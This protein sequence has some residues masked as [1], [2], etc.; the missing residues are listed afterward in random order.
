MAAPD[1]LDTHERFVR[2]ERGSD[3]GAPTLL[4]RGREVVLAQG[5]VRFLGN[6]GREHEGVRVTRI[7]TVSAGDHGHTS[8]G[9]VRVEW[10][11]VDHFGARAIIDPATVTISA[12]CIWENS[13]LARA[14]H[15]HFD[16]R[17]H[18]ASNP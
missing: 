3:W 6:D 10:I 17:A 5:P 16:S 2:L 13:P 12:D 7:E 4:Y 8:T 9:S 1:T 11:E 15:E 18:A 14:H